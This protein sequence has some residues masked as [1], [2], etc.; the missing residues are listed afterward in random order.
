[1]PTR[2]VSRSLLA[3]PTAIVLVPGPSKI[4]T[5]QF[6]TGPEGTGWTA[7]MLNM[8]PDVAMLSLPMQS[9]RWSAPRKEILRFSGSKLVLVVGVR[10]GPVSHKLTVLT[11]QP[12]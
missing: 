2:S 12:P 8:L 7:L 10:Y 3:S 9:G 4:P 11:D 1:M 5:P 6:P